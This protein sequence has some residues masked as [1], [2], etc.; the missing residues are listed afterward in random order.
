M[1]P[2]DAVNSIYRGDALVVAGDARQLPPTSFFSAATDSDDDDGWDEDDVSFE[3]I[4]DG[5]KASGSFV[6]SRFGGTTGVDTKI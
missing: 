1:L 4:L 5:C 6:R 2:Q 3:S